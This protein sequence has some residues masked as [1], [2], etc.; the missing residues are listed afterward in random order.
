MMNIKEPAATSRVYHQ[1]KGKSSNEHSD[2]VSF[3][4]TTLLV[5][6]IQIL[7]FAMAIQS[8]PRNIVRVN[9]NFGGQ[10]KLVIDKQKITINS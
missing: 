2:R 8:W 1:Q 9:V 6:Y 10:Q 7:F 4:F 3:L 5:S